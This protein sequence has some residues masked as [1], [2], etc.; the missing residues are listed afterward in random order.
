MRSIVWRMVALGLGVSLVAACG[1]P[2]DRSSSAVPGDGDTSTTL[3][4]VEVPAAN[5]RLEEVARV[6]RPTALAYRN[7]SDDVFVAAQPGRVR[8]IIAEPNGRYRLDDRPLIDIS[9]EVSSDG[10]RGL[11]GLAFSP[12]G[13]QLYLHFT[14]RQGTTQIVRYAM[15][16]QG[17]DIASR[18]LVFTTPQPFANHNGGQLAFGPDGYLYIGLGDG[19]GAGDPQ[20]NAQNPNSPLGKVL[21]I[22]PDGALGDAAYGIPVDNPFAD[23]TAG[24]PEVWLWGLRNPWRFSFDRSTGDLWLA[25][26]GQRSIEEINLLRANAPSR[27]GANLGWPSREGTQPYGDA[28][29]TTNPATSEPTTSSPASS[30]PASDDFVAPVF[31]YTHDPGCAVIGGFVYR[32]KDIEALVGTY[33]FGD[34]CDP[35]LRTLRVAEDGRVGEG[36]LGPRLNQLTAFG[37]DNRGELWALSAEGGVYR[38]RPA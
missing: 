16:A 33:V 12:D 29:A 4:P 25:D 32:G 11:L 30:S 26:V 5:V 35:A 18:Q 8:R 13:R 7:G 21:R 1:S 2:T 19:G 36:L 24:A 9:S 37:E 3:Q 6:D 17:V 31:E 34:W 22:D 20:G 38:L 28:P 15:A 10:E 14:D 23:G 27:S